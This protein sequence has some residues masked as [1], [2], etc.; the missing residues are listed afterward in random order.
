MLRGTS[1]GVSICLLVAL[2]APP[3]HAQPSDPELGDVEA[4]PSETPPPV[5]SATDDEMVFSIDESSGDEPDADESPIDSRAD[6]GLV[7]GAK[8]GGGFGTGDFGATPVFELELGFAPDLGDSLGHALEI[9]L[10]GQYAQPGLDGSSESD[11]RFPGGAAFSYD[12]SQQ[13]FSL[14]LGALWRFDVGSDLLMPYAGLGGRLYLLKTKI[15]GEAG[16]EPL[17]DSSETQS[18][19]GL[20]LL[21]GLEAFVGPG[22]LL[23]ELSFGWASLDSYILRDTDAGALSLAVGYRVML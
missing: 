7:L 4:P 14:S 17:G 19:V 6:V 1:L 11:P 10:I 20:V 18:K 5:S 21:G 8:V 2:C 15:E 23:G 16:G 13:M 12:V 9:F 22:A 3:A